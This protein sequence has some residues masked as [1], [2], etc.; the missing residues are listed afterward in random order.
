M[1]YDLDISPRP[2]ADLPISH[3]QTA[4]IHLRAVVTK[5]GASPVL[6]YSNFLFWPIC[7]PDKFRYK[8]WGKI[9]PPDVTWVSSLYLS[10]T[11]V[12]HSRNISHLCSSFCFRGTEKT[13]S[14]TI[15]TTL[16][17]SHLPEHKVCSTSRTALSRFYSGD[18]DKNMP[19]GLVSLSTG[20]LSCRCSNV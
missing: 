15:L 12:Y 14:S 20:S 8:H 10:K 11:A 6:C 2:P 13:L 4:R 19:P 5:A 9:V 3:L 17:L 7:L 18:S 1:F 16:L